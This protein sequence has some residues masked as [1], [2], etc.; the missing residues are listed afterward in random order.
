MAA[1]FF[2]VEFREMMWEGRREVK[3]GLPLLAERDET[4]PGGFGDPG[5]STAYLLAG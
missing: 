1:Q 3:Q 4:R 5:K 2:L